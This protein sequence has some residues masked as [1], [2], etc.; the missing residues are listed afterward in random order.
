MSSHAALNPNNRRYI[1]YR[2]CPEMQGQ[3][4]I[5]YSNETRGCQLRTFARLVS[6]TAY[7]LAADNCLPL[8]K[9]PVDG[10][11]SLRAA[12]NEGVACVH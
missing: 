11:R 4:Q 8:R 7:G 3:D 2:P 12:R 6:T 9:M 10:W 1:A 5:V